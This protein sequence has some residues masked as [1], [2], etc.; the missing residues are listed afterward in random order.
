MGRFRMMG[1]VL[2]F[3]VDAQY[4]RSLSLR[5]EFLQKPATIEDLWWYGRFRIRQLRLFG[6]F[7]PHGAKVARG[8]ILVDR[9]QVPTQQNRR[10]RQPAKKVLEGDPDGSFA[11]E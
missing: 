7:F 4:V 9:F 2:L 11:F 10:E 1:Q 8:P 3:H 5:P 6:T